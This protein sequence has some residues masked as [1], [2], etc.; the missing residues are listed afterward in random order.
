LQLAVS[1]ISRI[2]PIITLSGAVPETV[3]FGKEFIIPTATV[4]FMEDNVANIT[5]ALIIAP[6]GSFNLVQDN[7][8]IASE[9]G[10]YTLRYYALDAYGNFELLEFEIVCK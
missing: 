8:F 4:E 10:N 5:Y 7:K 1:A 2:K 3:E 9:A 6:D